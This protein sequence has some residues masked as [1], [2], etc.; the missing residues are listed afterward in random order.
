MQANQ[1]SQWQQVWDETYR[2]SDAIAEPTFNISGW[3]SSYTGQPIP[4]PE[5]KEWV[6]GIAG[7]IVALCPE[8]VLELG[9]GTG[10]ILFQV[11]P[12]CTEYVGSDFSQVALDYVQ[13]QLD[14]P[15][16]DLPSVRLLR[17]EASGR[18]HFDLWAANQYQLTQAGLSLVDVS[19]LCTAC[20]TDE[21]FSHRAEK[22]RTGRL[23]ALIG[24]RG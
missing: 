18:W 21:W 5:M 4:A 16:L 7:R 10:L 8:R 22:G 6:D 23:G 15:D 12:H 13:Q 11:A 14:R 3:N 2:L 17:R 19:G 9:C 20:R 1:V 24:L